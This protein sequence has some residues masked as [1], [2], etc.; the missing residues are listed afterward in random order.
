MVTGANGFVGQALGRLLQ[1]QALA[2]R[3]VL[4]QANPALPDALIMD[5]GPDSDWLPNLTDVQ[6]VIHLAARVHM[7][8]EDGAGAISPISA[9]SA[10]RRMN[11]D[12]TLRLARQAAQAGVTRFVYVSSIKVNGEATSLARPFSLRDTPSPS[13][14]YGISKWEAEQGLAQIAAETGLQVVVIRPPLVYGPQ[15]KANFLQLLRWV[16]RGWPLPLG[17]VDNRRSMIYVGNL[18]H[19]ILLCAQ[20]PAAA[21]QTFLASDGMDV[22]T[23][24]LIRSVARAMHRRAPLFACPPALLR[25]TARLLGKTPVAE[26]LLGSL[27]V[28]IAAT[29]Q[30]LAWTPPVSFDAGIAATVDSFQQSVSK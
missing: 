2:W 14:P 24:Q 11:V 12:A 1:S 20:H 8:N 28:D 18:V 21:G 7:L 4:R 15:V 25:A 17:S 6:C 30:I 9:I 23:S 16:R 27:Q 13:D 5:I 3:P 29:R 22:S 19:L 26:R 10:Y